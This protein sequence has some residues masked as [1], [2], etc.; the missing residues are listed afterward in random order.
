[1][2]RPHPLGLT[3]HPEWERVERK[4]DRLILA[5]RERRYAPAKSNVGPSL[6]VAVLGALAAAI[7]LVG[8]LAQ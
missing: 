3:S 2:T 7:G 8:M 5:E 6:V 4:R 1:M